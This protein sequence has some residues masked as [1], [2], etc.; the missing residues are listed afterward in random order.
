MHIRAGMLF[1]SSI[2][3][4]AP[5]FV[6]DIYSKS[7]K[8]QIYSSQIYSYYFLMNGKK[9]NLFINECSNFPYTPQLHSVPG[10]FNLEVKRKATFKNIYSKF[11]SR[12]EWYKI[13]HVKDQFSQGLL[14]F[15]PSLGS[16]SSFQGIGLLHEVYWVLIGHERKHSSE[17]WSLPNPASSVEWLV[18]L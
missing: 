2:V 12:V 11:N 15:H 16:I 9:V 7:T 17:P 13:F 3:S 10:K 18:F 4:A 8:C 14:S 6:A 5:R 1:C